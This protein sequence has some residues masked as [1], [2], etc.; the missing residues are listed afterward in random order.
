MTLAHEITQAKRS[1]ITDAYQMSVGEIVNLYKDSELVI[2]PNFQRL[3]RWDIY[4]KSRLFESILLGIPLPSIFVFEGNKGQW[5]LVD[6]LQRLSTLLEFMGLLID[7]DTQE[8]M[9]P[10][11][12]IGTKYLPSLQDAVWETRDESCEFAGKPLDKNQQTSIRRSRL[13]IEILKQPS[14]VH[15]K[16]DLFQRLNAGGTTANSQELRNVIAIMV[17]PE[18]LAA[19]KIASEAEDFLAL[20]QVT[21]DAKTAQRH[22]EHAMRFLVYLLVD[23]NPKKDVQEY[24]DDGI[25]SIAEQNNFAP[26]IKVLTQTFALIRQSLGDDGL[27]RIENSRPKGG[28]GLGAFEAIGV[29]IGANI[30]QIRKLASPEE[31]VRQRVTDFWKQ[32]DINKFFMPGLRGTQR[33]QRTLP[34]GRLW[35][36]P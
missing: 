30:K 13:S 25:V 22:V 27:K 31:F 17:N 15:T 4:Q 14:D 6:G 9:T 20:I 29:G 32:S 1:V 23:Y 34:F 35:F 3:Y 2:N 33:I 28:V 12:L 21:D 24:I 7:P 8:P 19:V 10:I 16:Y 36:K 18:F 5:E 26:G 11:S